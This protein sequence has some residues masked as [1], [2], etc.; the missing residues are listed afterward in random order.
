MDERLRNTLDEHLRNTEKI[1]LKNKEYKLKNKE[2]INEYNK[3]YYEKNKEKIREKFQCDCGGKYTKSH[4][5]D[6]ERTNK[7]LAFINR[8]EDT[9]DDEEFDVLEIHDK[10]NKYLVNEKTNELYDK[11]CELVGKAYKTCVARQWII[12]LN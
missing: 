7:H 10:Y 3:K 6:H 8:E 5:A 1:A 11:D 4:K 9:S 2:K 12:S